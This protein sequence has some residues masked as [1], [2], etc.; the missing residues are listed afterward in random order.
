[1]SKARDLA[2]AGTAL[3]AV[4]A[5]ELG[6]VD[7]VTSAI[8]TQIDSKEATLP[9]QTGNSGKY[10]TTN[11]TAKSWGTVSQYALPSQTGN[12]GKYL[13]T[14]GTAESWGT[15]TTPLTW[16][17]RVITE[18]QVN[19][20]AYNGSNMYVAGCN[21]GKLFSSPDGITW[22]ERTSQFASDIIL[23]VAYGNGL[24]VAVGDSGKIS[25]S[26]DGETWT[27]RTANMATNTIYDVIYANSIW[28]AVGAAGGNTNTGGITYSTDGITWTRKS[29]TLSVGTTYIQVVYNGS[30]FIVFASSVV[31]TNNYLYASTPSGTWTAGSDGTGTGTVSAF[32]DGTRIIKS[33]VDNG[34]ILYSTSATYGTGTSLLGTTMASNRRDNFYYNGVI[35]STSAFITGFKTTPGTGNCASRIA[36]ILNPTVK[37]TFT[38]SST[39]TSDSG[40]IFVGSAGYILGASRTIWTSF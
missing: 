31:S 5:T 30:N 18:E 40:A 22:T 33:R 16:T 34:S 23:K 24:W 8:Q 2:N 25:T 21:N 38:D 7:G 32:Y 15:V 10:L 26:P 27:A 20:I 4:T 6:Y 3:G 12:S 17:E 9:S 39:V 29:Q 36:A 19:T 1:M 37:L 11:G 13:T 35:Y 14:N 28:V